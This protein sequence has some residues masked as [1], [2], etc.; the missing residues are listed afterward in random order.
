[1]GENGEKGWEKV[2]KIRNFINFVGLAKKY[3]FLIL[4]FPKVSIRSS[5]WP[6][7]TDESL[8]STPSKS[9]T[10]CASLCLG[11]VTKVKDGGCL[12]FEYSSRYWTSSKLEYFDAFLQDGNLPHCGRKS[13]IEE[14]R[15]FGR[16]R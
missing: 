6:S 1:M 11:L 10:H 2:V 7:E 3:F 8:S 5:S 4:S 14:V 16:S 9:L 13:Y 12:G 15:S